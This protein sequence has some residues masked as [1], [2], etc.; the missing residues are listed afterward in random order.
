MSS[1]TQILKYF[2]GRNQECQWHFWRTKDGPEID[3]LIETKGKI[4]PFEIKMGSVS[5]ADLVSLERICEKN[6]VKGHV[7]SPVD[8][9]VSP[10]VDWNLA[11]PDKICEDS[12]WR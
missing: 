8:S 10:H 9:L 1:T 6:W 11:T 5:A 2:F 12:F 4:F 7:I 3:L